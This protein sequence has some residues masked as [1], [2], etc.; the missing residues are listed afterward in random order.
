MSKKFSNLAVRRNRQRRILQAS[1]QTLYPKLK[2]GFDIVISYTNRDK[3]LPYRDAVDVL[4]T[5]L[6]K[7]KLI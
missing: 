3:V 2:P 4:N 1:A 5:I 6:N 7:I